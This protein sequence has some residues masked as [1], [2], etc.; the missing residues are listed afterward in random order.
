LQGVE[1]LHQRIH[2]TTATSNMRED[3]LGSQ[4]LTREVMTTLSVDKRNIK[5]KNRDRTAAE[6]VH[7]GY[8]SKKKRSEYEAMMTRACDACSLRL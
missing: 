6:H 1:A 5:L 4:V 2:K 3:S 8:M 7:E